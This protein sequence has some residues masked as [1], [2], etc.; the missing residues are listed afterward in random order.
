VVLAALVAVPVGTQ[1]A[2]A[3]SYGLS[4]PSALRVHEG[5]MTVTED[6]AV[7]E[8]LEIRGSLYID[9]SNVTVRNVWVYTPGFW[10]VYVRS[11]SATFEHV[12]IGHP[13][14]V[15]ERGIGGA[16]VTGRWLDI[17]H[18]E[19]GIK[20][21][22]NSL[23]EYVWV[24]D[25]ATPNSNP[26]ADAVQADGGQWNA[27]VRHAILDVATGPLA[28]RA[29]A[30][31]QLGADLGTLGNITIEDSYLNGGNYTVFVNPG[32]TG[33]AP[34]NIRF[35]DNEFGPDHKYGTI[36]LY[37]DATIT[38]S[39]NTYTTDPPTTATTTTP[40]TTTTS[41]RFRGTFR[42]DDGSM[43]E[44]DIERL[45]AAGVTHGCNPPA[46]DRFCPD[47]RATRAETA[48][49]LARALRLPAAGDAF[50][51]DEASLFEADIDA[52]AAAGLTKG[53]N[54]PANDRFCPDDY[55]TRGQVAAF[56]ARLLR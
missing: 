28:P 7:I 50:R 21:G 8:D 48:S 52:I 41:E 4:N 53:C 19:D 14:F 10:T 46:N 20:L 2:G 25:L 27:T 18:V 22:S 23:Y 32:Q 13:S 31:I 15:N 54:P 12:E 35:I 11:G 44:H 5:S 24:H 43:F 55:V 1:G 37:G 49:L 56:L 38:A 9:A 39:G 36:A 29:N 42:D 30:A 45:A 3:A 47:K 34:T 51:D 16:N 40:P 6:G 26:H 17:H 33:I